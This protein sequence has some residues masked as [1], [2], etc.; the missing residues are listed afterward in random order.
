[1]KTLPM[2]SS[3]EPTPSAEYPLRTW[4]ANGRKIEL[5]YSEKGELEAKI[6]KGGTVIEVPKIWIRGIPTEM[7]MRPDIV[8][9]YV[10]NTWVALTQSRIGECGITIHDRL[11]GGMFEGRRHIETETII[12]KVREVDAYAER[13][14]SGKDIVLVIG[15]TGA[16]KSTF[17]N[18]LLGCQMREVPGNTEKKVIADNPIMGIGHGFVS[19][20]ACPQLYTDP[21]TH[22]TYCDCP[23][24]LDTRG[25]S[26]DIPN[27]F[28]IKAITRYARSI[29]GIVV[30]IG[31]HSLQADRAKGLSETI[32]ML[33]QLLGGNE[34]T[35]NAY[36]DSIAI[37]VT[38]G[39][40]S[41]TLNIDILRSHM[42]EAGNPIINRLL[43]N[44]VFYDP[45]DRKEFLDK[46][47]T[48]RANMLEG[49]RAAPGT[50]NAQNLFHVALGDDSK[51]AL[52]EFVNSTEREIRRQFQ[53]GNF[54]EVN[55]L[56][57][58]LQK[59]QALNFDLLTTSFERI[60]NTVKELIRGLQGDN[61]LLA[62][63]QKIRDEI[64][65]FREEADAVIEIITT[66]KREQEA[67]EAATKA[68]Q[69]AATAATA[70][71]QKAEEIA[72]QTQQAV[73]QAQRETEQANQRIKELQQR[74]ILA[75]EQARKAASTPTVIDLAA[76]Y[77]QA[78]LAPP[79]QR[80]RSPWKNILG[81]LL[82]ATT[83]FM[84]GG[85]VGLV[86]GGLSGAMGIPSSSAGSSPQATGHQ[87][88]NINNVTVSPQTS[89]SQLSSPIQ[90]TTPGRQPQPSALSS[91]LSNASS[92]IASGS[93]VG[94]ATGGPL[95]ALIGGTAGLTGAIVGE[96]V[97]RY[98]ESSTS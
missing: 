64:S 82:G 97:K 38:Q 31:Y 68:A 43:R 93:L 90:L 21:D 52:K 11:S 33:T 27:A 37:L 74:I 59:L 71:K 46:G 16:G 47:A 30:L 40:H 65:C 8:K 57:E 63:L 36:S 76:A 94:L 17:I 69:E 10:K 32:H 18:Y 51:L 48:S 3:I 66:R 98:T 55:R 83:G 60:A 50:E 20:T 96:G 35:I 5:F 92:T 53:A 67:R 49:L 4:H 42:Q 34:N 78:G 26:F 39:Q 72:R 6:T 81:G 15:N 84:T 29:K 70:N 13:E 86:T 56:I 54:T 89:L 7:Q 24:F 61:E 25:P 12:T 79:P 75:E 85:P 14:A 19:L 95:G 88:T 73:E 77:P 9:A 22:I 62:Q 80:R 2:S 91:F 45:L 87:N 23:G 1:M 58:P 41:E 28:A 44:V